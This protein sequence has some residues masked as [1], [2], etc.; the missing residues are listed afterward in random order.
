[1]AVDPI[2]PI[3]GGLAGG[4]APVSFTSAASQA[5]VDSDIIVEWD[6]DNDGVFETPDEDVTEYVMSLETQ[7]GRDWP[8]NLQGQASAG[9]LRMTLLNDDDRFSYFNEDSPLNQDGKSLR[10]GRKVRVR[11]AE[12]TPSDPILLARDRFN[13]AGASVHGSADELGNVWGSNAGPVNSFGIVNNQARLNTTPGSNLGNFLELGDQPNM[14][15]QVTVV[16][17]PRRLESMALAVRNTTGAPANDHGLWL[18]IGPNGLLLQQEIANVF[19]DIGTYAFDPYPGCT[20]GVSI[21]A[22]DEAIAWLNG[23]P[24]IVTGASIPITGGDFGAWV[25]AIW[26]SD[27]AIGP[28][29][30]NFYVW[31][32]PTLTTEGVIWTGD[33]DEINVSV[34][35]GGTKIAEV[36]ANGILARAASAQVQSPQVTGGAMTG[37]LVGDT[38]T[39][40]DLMLPPGDQ[41][42]EGYVE[43]GPVYIDDGDAL[44][45]ARQFEN[46]EFGFIYETPEGPPGFQS[47]TSRL[48]ATST[49]WWTDTPGQGQY[50]YS[51]I[52]PLNY[53]REVVNRVTAGLA[54][55]APSGISLT[56]ITDSGSVGV[57]NHVDV[58]LPTVNK[59]DLLVVF[60]VSTVANSDVNWLVPVWWKMWRD[61]GSD[62]RTRL[63]DHICA[64]TE[65]GTTVRFYQDD[66]STGGSWVAHV[67]RIRNWF[68]GMQGTDF[69]E[70]RA[71][72]TPPPIEPKWGKFPTIYFTAWGAMQSLGPSIGTLQAPAGYED[73][74]TADS[75]L[76][77]AG[78]EVGLYTAYRITTGGTESPVGEF[79]GLE[80][81]IIYD[82][83]TY[84]VRGFN[85]AFPD[86]T[87]LTDVNLPGGNGRF[88][89]QDDTESQ[90]E[91]NAIVSYE[92][93]S[94]LFDSE[95]DAEEY[96]KLVLDT[97]ADDRPIIGLTFPASKRAELREQA[98]SRRVGDKISV[99]ANGVTGLGFERDFF[100]ESINHKWANGGKTWETTWE[101]SP[102]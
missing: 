87:S 47:R 76:T 102:A 98:Y 83:M 89:T 100:I 73:N 68:E 91:H 32:K 90:A 77:P 95:A 84:A 24:V 27:Y 59:G 26:N 66:T 40:A 11:T 82:T 62:I 2:N 21:D 30:D 35:P 9:Q 99:T 7:T 16:T 88:V 71:G 19:S 5:H 1:M 57:A 44:S 6:F 93:S 96:V 72:N 13:R 97:Y 86:P 12:S 85:G 3:G 67:Y 51:G 79:D 22:N 14:Y 75:V 49:G 54:A 15:A 80:G 48:T 65:S 37:L 101:L 18:T 36:T 23:V 43:T 92:A 81:F 45:I 78:G 39:R 33:I 69:A 17:P 46:T 29:V 55:D 34:T 60:I 94:D 53:Q 58:T 52:E 10:T 74:D 31:D 42:E 20:I 56:R 25:L 63:Y 50:K 41:I 38:F 4:S 28:A 8:S 64:G 70:P 61:A